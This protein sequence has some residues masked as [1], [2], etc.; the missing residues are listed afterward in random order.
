[1]CYFSFIDGLKTNKLFLKGGL[2]MTR[3]DWKVSIVRLNLDRRQIAEQLGVS[4]SSLSQRMNGFQ[5]WQNNEEAQ[6]RAIIRKAEIEQNEK[7]KL[8][9]AEAV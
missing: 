1:L 4:Y 3:E 5:K 8:K 2:S 9:T 7:G 6:F